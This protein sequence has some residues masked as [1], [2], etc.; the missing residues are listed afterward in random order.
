MTTVV[1][2]ETDDAREMEM[3]KQFAVSFRKVSKQNVDLLISAIDRIE[4]PDAVVTDVESIE[5][6]MNNVQA[7]IVRQVNKTVNSVVPNISDISTFEFTCE[8]CDNIEKVTFELN[9]VNFS[10]AG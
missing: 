7:E 8:A 10:S 2:Q 5:E 1:E 4:T 6:F 3:A 9:P